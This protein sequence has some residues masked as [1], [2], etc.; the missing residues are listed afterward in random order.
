MQEA[1]ADL[2][3]D[4]LQREQHSFQMRIGMHF[5]PAIVGSF[6]GQKRSDYTAIGQTVNLASRIESHAKPGEI[7]VTSSVRDYLEEEQWEAAGSFRFKGVANEVM[8][9]RIIQREQKSAA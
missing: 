4:W 3:K 7:L 2:N 5:G 6:G 1:L 8:L 9:F